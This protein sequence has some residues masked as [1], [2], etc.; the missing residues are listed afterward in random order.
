MLRPLKLRPKRAVATFILLFCLGLPLTALAGQPD[1]LRIAIMNGNTDQFNTVMQGNI[2]ISQRI[3]DG[4]TYL[5]LSAVHAN[6]TAIFAS[7]LATKIDANAQDNYGKT[8]LIHACENNFGKDRIE[9][10]RMLLQRKVDVNLRTTDQGRSPLFFAIS[11]GDVEVVRLL[12]KAKADVLTI[13]KE[14]VPLLTEAVLFSQR[15]DGDPLAIVKLLV[16]AGARVND[17]DKNGNTPLMAAAET[18]KRGMPPVVRFLIKR[19]ANVNARNLDGISVLGRLDGIDEG[20]EGDHS[21][22]I[23]ILK[24]AGAKR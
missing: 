24:A 21:E 2:D 9:I 19:G 6:S 7:L 20:T 16:T 18:G 4:K 13:D 5:M 22:V 3:D 1:Q 10:I 8:A 14:G 11:N 12:I 23:K 15:L 17:H